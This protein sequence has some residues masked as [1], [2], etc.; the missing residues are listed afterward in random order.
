MPRRAL[1]GYAS[2]VALCLATV[3]VLEAPWRYDVIGSDILGAGRWADGLEHWDRAG[4]SVSFRR[5]G[6]LQVICLGPTA[7]DSTPLITT[8]FPVP[9]QVTHLKVSAEL[10]SDSLTSGPETWQRGY[11]LSL[12]FDHNRQAIWYWP[13]EVAA[14]EGSTDWEEHSLV[15]PLAGKVGGVRLIAYNG[16]TAGQFCMRSLRV[17]ALR[18][19]RFFEALRYLLWVFWAAALLWVGYEVVRIPGPVLPKGGVLATGLM[20][21]VLILMPQPYFAAITGPLETQIGRLWLGAE[22]DATLRASDASSATLVQTQEGATPHAGDADLEKPNESGQEA[23]ANNESRPRNTIVTL[24]ALAHAAA[25]F[26]LAVLSVLAFGHAGLLACL[27][28]LMLAVLA[29]EVMQLMVITRDSQWDDLLADISGVA[30]GLGLGSL[31]RLCFRLGR[32]PP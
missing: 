18:E 1:V 3:L 8:A 4:E 6:A 26:A 10:R 5:D 9:A 27:V 20:M 19:V 32:L 16:A 30:L 31:L 21:L 29:S 28:S 23:I 24:E 13:R 15:V 7:K 17:T 11:L 14:V 12:S 2:V 22:P 25:F